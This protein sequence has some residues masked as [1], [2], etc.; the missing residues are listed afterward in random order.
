MNGFTT[1]LERNMEKKN[2][3][4][5]VYLTIN[6]EVCITLHSLNDG[7]EEEI[8]INIFCGVNEE[9]GKTCVHYY[10]DWEDC[11]T[12][13][14]YVQESIEE[15]EKLVEEAKDMRITAYEKYTIVPCDYKKE[16]KEETVNNICDWLYDNYWYTDNV[17]D[18]HKCIQEL[19]DAFIK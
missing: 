5:E 15:V 9:N 4:I 12:G 10:T 14:F 19:R 18:K 7:H 16:V 1:F 6:P 8:D 3:N 2:K 11:P 13:Y 17:D